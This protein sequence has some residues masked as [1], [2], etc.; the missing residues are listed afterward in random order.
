[1]RRQ[2][3]MS[4]PAESPVKRHEPAVHVG[5]LVHLVA[6]STDVDLRRAQ[7]RVSKECPHDVDGCAAS[8]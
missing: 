5:S 8:H 4:C 7:G 2:R 6:G 1:M 3:L